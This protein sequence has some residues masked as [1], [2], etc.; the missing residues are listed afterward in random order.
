MIARPA[1]LGLVPGEVHLF[2]V[3]VADRGPD[4]LREDRAL[5]DTREQQLAARFVFDKDRNLYTVAHAMLRRSLS[6][7]AHVN[8]VSWC[9][10][11]GS[12][13]RPELSRAAHPSLSQLRFNLSHSQD[14]AVCAVTTKFDVGIDVEK[15]DRVAPLDVADR[16]FAPSEVAALRALPDQAQSERF[17][18]YWT[19]KESYIKARGLGLSLPLEQFAFEIKERRPVRISFGEQIRDEP[20]D[21]VFETWSLRQRYQVSLGVRSCGTEIAVTQHLIQP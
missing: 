17:F 1:V 3:T 18:Q 11:F 16:F 7:F 5:L 6:L 12:H 14:I 10:E 21:W 9:F 2:A 4:G 13:G 8:P 20:K 19:L 15:T